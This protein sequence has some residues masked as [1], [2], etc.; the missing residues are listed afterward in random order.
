MVI[1]K[2]KHTNRFEPRG[3]FR[4]ARG[5]RK[6]ADVSRNAAVGRG[7]NT[8]TGE[9]CAGH[10]ARVKV[11]THGGLGTIIIIAHSGEPK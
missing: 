9:H 1:L 8:L 3:V 5:G 10:S 6:S 11:A 2:Q 7:A 4:N